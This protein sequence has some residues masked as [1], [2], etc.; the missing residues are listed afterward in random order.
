MDKISFCANEY[1]RGIRERHLIP[2]YGDGIFITNL[3]SSIDFS[4][5]EK[6][7]LYGE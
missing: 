3:M 1:F 4:N 2:P 5:I 6:Q 7:I